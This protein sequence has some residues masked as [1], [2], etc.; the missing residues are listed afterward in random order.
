MARLRVIRPNRPVY[1][2]EPEAAGGAMSHQ[3]GIGQSWQSETTLLVDALEQRIAR[4]SGRLVV[5]Q[6]LMS[7]AR[8]ADIQGVAEAHGTP[9]RWVTSANAPR[10]EVDVPAWTPVRRGHASDPR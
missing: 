6:D 2:G 1:C 5:M 8:S 7:T 3:P 4:K 10:C 9:F